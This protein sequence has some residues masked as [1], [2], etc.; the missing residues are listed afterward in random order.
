[1]GYC[2]L[3]IMALF[4]LNG[5]NIAGWT[6]VFTPGFPT[7]QRLWVFMERSSV[8]D[9]NILGEFN[10]SLWWINSV[11]LSGCRSC[12]VCSSGWR[13]YAAYLRQA[14]E[15]TCRILQIGSPP[16]RF[17]WDY[18]TRLRY[19]RVRVSISILSPI[20]QNSGTANSKP[21]AILAGFITFPDVSPLTAGSV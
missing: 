17:Q 13:Q 14:D 8:F 9:R 11:H 6:R 16:Y 7:L 4:Y 15:P 20:S 21:V 19:S 2:E 12:R 10:R 5:W 18:K 3:P 1:M